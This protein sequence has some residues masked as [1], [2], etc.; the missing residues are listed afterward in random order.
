[1]DEIKSNA[2]LA[3]KPGESRASADSCQMGEI[4]PK[5]PESIYS[6]RRRA[7]TAVPVGRRRLLLRI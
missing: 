5:R 2:F 1:M 3:E 6:E 7:F 4:F